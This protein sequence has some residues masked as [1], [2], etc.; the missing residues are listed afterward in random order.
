MAAFFS[1]FGVAI[2]GALFVRILY[3]KLKLA[4][5]L[6][7][8]RSLATNNDDK[9]ERNTKRHGFL[10]YRSKTSHLNEVDGELEIERMPD[11]ELYTEV[12]KF[13]VQSN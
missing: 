9:H 13:V 5:Q 3:P 10:R 11:M 2:L 6:R 12:G 7:Q 1:I 4:L 8:Q